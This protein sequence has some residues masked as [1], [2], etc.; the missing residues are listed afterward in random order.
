MAGKKNKNN[1]GIIVAA[2]A[3]AALAIIALSSFMASAYG[4]SNPAS[5]A[6]AGGNGTATTTTIQYIISVDASG[7]AYATPTEV[8]VSLYVNGTGDTA[9]QA[10]QNIS[11]SLDALNATIYKYT[12]GNMSLVQTTSYSMTPE[13]VL[14]A[15]AYEECLMQPRFNESICRSLGSSYMTVYL[16]QESIVVTL[17]STPD[18]SPFLG[19]MS[20]IPHVRVDSATAKLTDSQINALRMEALSDAMQ[21][22][23]D[24]AQAVVGAYT[25][26]TTGNITIN[27]VLYQPYVYN[28]A[29]IASAAA[30]PTAT[31]TIPMPQYYVG[32]NKVYDSIS[33]KFMYAGKSV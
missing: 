15:T 17:P 3:V 21:N 30:V 28:G 25:P 19:S 16:A 9:A 13:S 7:T 24:Q 32:Q 2:A 31:T 14:N 5:F 12:A 29:Y 10:T 8:E 20:G 22:A 26:L 18:V 33:V 27:S 11:S 6:G 23:T 4:R 1:A